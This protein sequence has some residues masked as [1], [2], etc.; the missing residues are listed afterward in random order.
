MDAVY[1][2]IE[3]V[4]TSTKDV[5]DAINNAVKKASQSLHH[6]S[7]FEVGEIRGRVENNAVTQYQVTVKIGFRLED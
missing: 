4:G 2:K 1:K 7:W 6:I 5:T 3:V